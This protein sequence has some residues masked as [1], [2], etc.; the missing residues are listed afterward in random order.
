MKVDRTILSVSLLESCM[1]LEPIGR[2]LARLRGSRT[3]IVACLKRFNFP[4]RKPATL[5]LQITDGRTVIHV[6][7]EEHAA[8]CSLIAQRP[9]ALNFEGYNAAER[10]AYP[11]S[12]LDTTGAPPS[13][14][15]D[16]GALAF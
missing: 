8:S 16:V 1:I 3:R 5:R 11:D 12:P 15:P 7:L 13:C 9:L 2:F 10:I 6:R 4:V 14:D